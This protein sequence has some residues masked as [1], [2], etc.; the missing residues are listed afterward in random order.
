MWLRERVDV[1]RML[2][3][4]ERKQL[5]DHEIPFSEDYNPDWNVM[6]VHLVDAA[7]AA[8]FREMFKDGGLLKERASL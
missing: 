3:D 2:T 8:Q 1:K 7:D 6:S 4:E 5:L